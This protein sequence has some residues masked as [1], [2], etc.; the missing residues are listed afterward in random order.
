MAINKDGTIVV[1]PYCECN[2]TDCVLKT[3]DSDIKLCSLELPLTFQEW[4]SLLR[5][6]DGLDGSVYVIS[7]NCSR[8]ADPDDE[9]LEE[10]G[11]YRVYRAVRPKTA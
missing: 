8:G 4:L 6:H 1:Q 5:K 10:T 7:A 2:S 11:S 3:K 9:V